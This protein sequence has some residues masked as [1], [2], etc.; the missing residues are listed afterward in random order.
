MVRHQEYQTNLHSYNKNLFLIITLC[1]WLRKSI[2]SH[3]APSRVTDIIAHENNK[4]PVHDIRC[5][6]YL[7]EALAD[8]DHEKSQHFL[9]CS[10]YPP[11]LIFDTNQNVAFDLDADDLS[12][13][14]HAINQTENEFDITDFWSRT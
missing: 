10:Y 5:A 6:Y 2:Q 12:N 8:S 9:E 1:S 13:E 7:F 4:L 3:I 11:C 14:N